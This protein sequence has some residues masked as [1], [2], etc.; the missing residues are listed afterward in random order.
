MSPAYGPA[1]T[2]IRISADTS[3]TYRQTQTN[4]TLAHSFSLSLSLWCMSACCAAPASQVTFLALGNGAAD[5]FGA[6]AALSG[7]SANLA[8]GQIVG[9]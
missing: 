8:I 1:H 3:T 5:V 6:Y 9:A 2:H 7:N 4:K